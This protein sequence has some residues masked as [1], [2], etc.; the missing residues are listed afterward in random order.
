MS[1]PAPIPPTAHG[2]SAVAIIIVDGNRFLMQQRDEKPDIAFAGMWGL[3]GGALI[4]GEDAEQG[5]R[6]EL[7]EELELNAHSCVYF[8]R[9]EFDL[10]PLGLRPMYRWFYE[11]PITLGE[12]DRLRLHEG[13]GMALFTTAEL[14]AE[15]RLSYHDGY[16]LWLYARREHLYDADSPASSG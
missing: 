16:A 11:V 14:F 7:K 3:F 12:F 6:R 5:L 4:P 8:T 2:D 9:F 1:A 15:T 10:Q 13:A